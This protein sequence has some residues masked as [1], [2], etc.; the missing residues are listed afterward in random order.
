VRLALV[1]AAG[2]LA[3][4]G[5]GFTLVLPLYVAG[6]HG[7]EADAGRVL[8][9][10]VLGTLL[11]VPFAGTIADRISADRLAALAALVF[12]AGI[13]GLAL[14]DRLGPF[15]FGCGF[16]LGCGWGLFFTATPM[17]VA[18][19]AD[20]ARRSQMFSLL[21]AFQ[22]VGI[23]GGPVLARA[24]LHAGLP[25]HAL[26]VASALANTVA[27]ALLAGG[28]F[29]GSRAPVPDEA[30]YAPPRLRD[31]AAVLRGP[32]AYPIAMVFL[33]AC[34]FSA[35]FNF[36]AG[37][38]AA[39][40][41]DYTV[42]YVT[43]SVVVIGLR[44]LAAGFVGRLSRDGATIG[45]LTMMTAAVALL[46]VTGAN[47]VYALAAALLGAGYGLVYPLIQA[48]AVAASP[49]FRPTLVL[50]VFS[51]SYFLGI[52]GFPFVAGYLIVRSGYGALLAVLLGLAAAETGVALARAVRGRRPLAASRGVS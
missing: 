19:Y 1:Y 45:L 11:C 43:Y 51:V 47:P 33:G 13:L 2:L 50:T 37:F 5:Y 29:A 17:V 23:G 31:V 48:Q 34:V 30:Q 49:Q 7:N 41:L 28:S 24:L 46:L 10:G 26:F 14:N 6:L 35:L 21:S 36:Q 3:A 8:S 22:M 44:F 39:R 16:L 25:F 27:A 32:A 18:R 15:L 12:G 4:L 52:F 9:A 40:G 20:D 38:A 42:F